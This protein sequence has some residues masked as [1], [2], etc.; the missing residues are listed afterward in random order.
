MK[1]T[2]LRSAAIAGLLAGFL[3]A[4][5]AQAPTPGTQTDTKE[6]EVFLDNHRPLI[7]KKDKAPTSRTVSGTVTDDTGLPLEGAL[8]EVKKKEKRTFFTKK[9]GKYSF[10]DLSFTEDYEVLAKWKKLVSEPRKI[11]QYDHSAKVIRL[12][13]VGTPEGYTNATAAAAQVQKTTPKN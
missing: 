5:H 11:S 4:A 3:S 8:V 2:I 9:D 7:E 12:L 6:P 1:R 10:S 13:Q